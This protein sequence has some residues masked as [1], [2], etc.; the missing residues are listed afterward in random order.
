M[1][2]LEAITASTMNGARLLGWDRI[3]GSLEPGKYA[4]VI[5]VAGDPSQDISRIRQVLFVMKDGTVYRNSR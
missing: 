3:I 5:A 1:R 4:D 2:P